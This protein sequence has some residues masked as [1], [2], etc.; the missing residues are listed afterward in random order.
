MHRILLVLVSTVSSGHAPMFLRLASTQK[1][2]HLGPSKNTSVGTIG[3]RV[4]S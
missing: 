2:S 4:N 1:V 3:Q